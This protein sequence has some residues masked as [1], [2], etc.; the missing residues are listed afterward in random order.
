MKFF[1]SP[2]ILSSDFRPS[3]LTVLAIQVE[4]NGIFFG[5]FLEMIIGVDRSLLAKARIPAASS[6]EDIKYDD[7]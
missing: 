1:E 4:Q 7:K 2:D 6:Y 3:I 5:P